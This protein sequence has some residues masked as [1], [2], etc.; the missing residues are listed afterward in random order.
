M[1]AQ[2]KSLPAQLVHDEQCEQLLERPELPQAHATHPA[3]LPASAN[4]R[5]N[6]ARER[7][8][9]LG[10]GAGLDQDL[11]RCAR[12]AC[13]EK[14]TRTSAKRREREHQRDEDQRHRRR[15]APR[16]RHRE[17]NLNYCS[18]TFLRF[19]LA[20]AQGS[21]VCAPPHHSELWAA[22]RRGGT[23]KGDRCRARD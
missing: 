2:C 3:Q 7:P 23:G 10:W 15:G 22:R 9:S 4:Q 21:S 1:C 12:R 13:S 5:R 16:S 18:S 19:V 6:F 17:R 11:A 14:H 8:L 20:R